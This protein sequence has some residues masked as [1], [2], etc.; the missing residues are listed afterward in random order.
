MQQVDKKLAGR[1]HSRLRERLL[2]DEEQLRDRLRQILA[3]LK[4]SGLSMLDSDPGELRQRLDDLHFTHSQYKTMER[5]DTRPSDKFLD[6]V[7][8]V[9]EVIERLFNIV[10][11]VLLNQPFRIF[12]LSWTLAAFEEPT[13]QP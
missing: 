1:T 12:C 2:P 8:E 5:K 7:Y 3:K 11:S 13:E 10:Q 4:G 9:G 6:Q